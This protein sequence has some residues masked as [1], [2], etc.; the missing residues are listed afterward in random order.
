MEKPKQPRCAATWGVGWIGPYES[1]FSLAQKFTWANQPS[2][3]R[4]LSLFGLRGSA[5]QSCSG[6]STLSLLTSDGMRNP[7]WIGRFL[8]SYAGPWARSLAIEERFRYCP[9]CIR[10][11]YQST[12]YQ[13]E[14]L[15]TCP[16]HEDRL[17]TECLACHRPTC[18]YALTDDAFR[19]PMCCAHCGS[20]WS[21]LRS[22]EE[23]M[24]TDVFHDACRACL[25]P[26]VAWLKSLRHV[27][28]RSGRLDPS[29]LVE[30]ADQSRTWV[31]VS[32]AEE[33]LKLCGYG[34]RVA[35]FWCATEAAPANLP[36]GRWQ[37]IDGT[38][39]FMKAFETSHQFQQV[40]Q[41]EDVLGFVAIHKSI[42]RHLTKRFMRPYRQ[43]LAR[44]GE[45]PVV[46][47]PTHPLQIDAPAV[48]QSFAIWRSRTEDSLGRTRVEMDEKSRPWEFFA[49]TVRRALCSSS[50]PPAALWAV[51]D[52]ILFYGLCEGVLAYLRSTPTLSPAKPTCHHV[53]QWL[54]RSALYKQCVQA[55]SGEE[56]MAGC[57][58]SRPVRKDPE[59]S[60]AGT[61]SATCVS[62]LTPGPQS[63]EALRRM[64]PFKGGRPFDH[65]DAHIIALR[66]SGKA[67]Q[68]VEL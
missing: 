11:G 68:R 8:D 10:H 26:L 50:P 30:S 13:I 2:A 41:V 21:G 19:D 15:L 5:L 31:S 47:G 23:W 43:W 38:W 66:C 49:P 40:R 52:L 32:A 14:G 35:A 4:L 42:R 62:I 48:L 3:H 1:P 59:V 24:R 9:A 22:N 64:D 46:W 16:I 63:V 17:I 67:A 51:S 56:L 12:L 20:P 28:L 18:S 44:L 57:R 39:H 36:T 34:V 45:E 61:D 53:E 25:T 6:S 58:V 37:T 7:I 60:V 27:P 55:R 29:V 54:M 33:L 65:S